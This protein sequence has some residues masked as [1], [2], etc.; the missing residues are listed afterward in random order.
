MSL[1][2]RSSEERTLHSVVSSMEKRYALPCR[3]FSHHQCCKLLALLQVSQNT[4][5]MRIHS[6]ED[7]T[8]HTYNTCDVLHQRQTVGRA[9]WLPG[10]L[11]LSNAAFFM[12]MST[13]QS[14][15]QEGM[16][17]YLPFT[18]LSVLPSACTHTY[19]DIVAVYFDFVWCCH[20]VLLHNEVEL[21]IVL[22]PESLLRGALVGLCMRLNLCV[23]AVTSPA[24][25]YC[26]Y[27]EG[28]CAT[29]ASE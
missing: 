12:L 28:V 9:I 24:P 7:S 3:L 26:V 17:P 6:V 22:S 27:V 23:S 10:L 1:S 11:G 18:F 4:V 19:S 8:P 29:S 13:M 16:P 2:E 14:R 15:R 5:Y 20:Q 21:N 25:H